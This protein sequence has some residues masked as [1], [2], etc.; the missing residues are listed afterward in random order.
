MNTV[1]ERNE[2]L[3][4]KIITD[5]GLVSIIMPN[6]NSA[7]FIKDSIDSVVAQTYQNWELIIVDDCS[8]DDSLKI[9]QQYDDSRIRVIKNTV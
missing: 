8:S 2:L 1:L 9:I 6:Y 5:Y 7:K 3:E 4:T